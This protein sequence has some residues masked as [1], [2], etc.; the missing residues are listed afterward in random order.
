VRL[1]DNLPPSCAVVKKFGSLNF[2]ELSGPV[3][4]YNGT[5]TS[6][7]GNGVI[8]SVNRGNHLSCRCVEGS[9]GFSTNFSP[10]DDIHLPALNRTSSLFIAIFR[11]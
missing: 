4:V 6:A 8:Q 9:E 7:T 3:Q 5:L 10:S 11:T 1:A 2:L